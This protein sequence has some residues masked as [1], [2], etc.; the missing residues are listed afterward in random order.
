MLAPK[1]HLRTPF[2]RSE[3]QCVNNA[4]LELLIQILA[5]N[6]NLIHIILN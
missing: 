5:T 6:F 3:K 1:N 4:Q 2:E